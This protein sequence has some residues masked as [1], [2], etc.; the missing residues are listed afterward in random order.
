MPGIE[1]LIRGM[2]K[3]HATM[4]NDMLKQFRMVKDNPQVSSLSLFVEVCCKRL[5]SRS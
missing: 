1:K 2:V 4:K 3:Y 5:L